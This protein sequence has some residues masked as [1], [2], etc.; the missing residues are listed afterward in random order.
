MRVIC[1]NC[2]NQFT[3]ADVDFVASVL[4]RGGSD[5]GLVADLLTDPGARD[6]MLD[7]RELVE[8]V[9]EGMG[10]LSISPRLYF[11]LLVR[12]ALR[13]ADIDD[14]EMADYIAEVL[15]VFTSSHRARNPLPDQAM[16]LDYFVD[17]VAALSDADDVNRFLLRAHVGNAA[18]FLVGLF[19][20]YVRTRRERRAAP[21]ARYYEGL[22]RVSYRIAGEHHL[23]ERYALGPV[24]HGLSDRF[25]T[26]RLALNDVADRLLWLEDRDPEGWRRLGDGGGPG[27]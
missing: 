23:A 6:L 15:S 7:R 2:R 3:A 21:D 16:P 1:P 25:H 27:T 20:G 24:L 5:A 26:A 17:M 9:L 8:A 18:L 22:G 11:Y 12:H 19:P 14:R 10:C 4:A 13:E